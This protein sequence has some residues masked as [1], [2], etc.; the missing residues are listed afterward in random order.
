MEVEIILPGESYTS[1]NSQL[2]SSIDSLSS[3]LDS[4][5]NLQDED[6]RSIAFFDEEV[7]GYILIKCPNTPNTNIS[8]SNSSINND[9]ATSNTTEIVNTINNDG[10]ITIPADFKNINILIQSLVV[11]DIYNDNND[12]FSAN[13]DDETLSLSSKNSKQHSV[14]KDKSYKNRI[15][16]INGLNSI[17]TIKLQEKDYIGCF[18]NDNKKVNG[19]ENSE[20]ADEEEEEEE[21]VDVQSSSIFIWKF[22]IPVK[23]PKKMSANPKLK[24]SV[25]IH[26]NEIIKKPESKFEFAPPEI[27]LKDKEASLNTIIEGSTDK[28]EDDDDDD[29]SSIL[30]L[31]KSLDHPDIFESLKE[32]LNLKDPIRINP[33]GKE[34]NKETDVVASESMDALNEDEEDLYEHLNLPNHLADLDQ[35]PLY[36]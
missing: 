7:R 30:H 22:V 26:S 34:E 32:T 2:S 9:T 28:V 4:L 31:S 16:N 5:Q 36:W 27:P 17:N 1:P 24:I 23:S 14:S 6:L 3:V 29:D 15:K 21:V 11:S 35:N 12:Q 25:E 13:N 19:N 20:S 33:T 18:K 8:T 10:D